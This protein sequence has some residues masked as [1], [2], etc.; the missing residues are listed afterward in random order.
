MTNLPAVQ[1]QALTQ[2]AFT[3][4]QLTLLKNTIAKGTSDDEFKLFLAFA[5]RKGLDPFKKQIYAI[6][7]GGKMAVVTGIDGYRAIAE[8]T[9]EH[10]GSVYAG[11]D[12]PSWGPDV[13]GHPEWADV[14]VYRIVQG[15]RV[16]F[17]SRAWWKDY[18]KVQKTN[19]NW[20][21]SP[22]NQLAVRAETSALRKGFPEGLSDIGLAE[23]YGRVINQQT[24]E[25]IEIAP[26][27]LTAPQGLGHTDR[28]SAT[29]TRPEQA[30]SPF[31][32]DS[33]MV[34]CPCG[35]RWGQEK[36][37]FGGNMTC[38][39][40]TDK[41]TEDGKTIF[42]NRDKVL[43]ELLKRAIEASGLSTT[44]ATDLIKDRFDGLTAS[45]LSDIQRY[46]AIGMV[47]K[48]H[49]DPVLQALE[50]MADESLLAIEEEGAP[51]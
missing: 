36:S 27:R 25:I 41:K 21:E 47:E 28:P 3:P 38:G 23:D 33:V 19:A 22:H 4:A 5:D 10:S 37:G 17:P 40:P 6:M 20:Q 34:V 44:E 29:P 9:K 24:G 15:I 42:H 31:P 7:Y 1:E 43:A 45:K 30:P 14:T 32:D 50:D 18:G 46:E 8:R 48:M 39:H 16:P 26:E 11:Q 35:T 2:R 51:A 12:L 49:N 13:D